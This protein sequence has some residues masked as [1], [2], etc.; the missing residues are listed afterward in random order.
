MDRLQKLVR[1]Y[2]TLPVSQLPD[3]FIQSNLLLQHLLQRQSGAARLIYFFFDDFTLC[4]DLTVS[5]RVRMEEVKARTTGQ[6][7]NW[8]GSFLLLWLHSF[9]LDIQKIH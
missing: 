6:V 9:R 3:A 5:E 7:S 8:L 4:A 1:F 2:I